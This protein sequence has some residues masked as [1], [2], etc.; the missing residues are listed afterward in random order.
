[1]Q[2]RNKPRRSKGIPC[3]NADSICPKNHTLV[4]TTGAKVCLQLKHTNAKQGPV[5]PDKTALIAPSV[6]AAPKGQDRRRGSQ[7]REESHGSLPSPPEEK[8]PRCF[9]KLLH[10][11]RLQQGEAKLSPEA[12]HHLLCGAFELRVL[13]T[14]KWSE[15]HH[16]KITS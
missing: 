6:S 2:T 13:F 15:N 11:P 14:L 16:E 1:M 12:K 4:S 8:A 9:L 3:A 7:D 5:C 10:L